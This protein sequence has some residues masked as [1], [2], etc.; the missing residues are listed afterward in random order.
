MLVWLYFHGKKLKLSVSDAKV[1]VGTLS[2][3]QVVPPVGTVFKVTSWTAAY[4]TQ[5]SSL[6]TGKQVSYTFTNGPPPDSLL[7]VVSNT[8][9]TTTFEV[10]PEGV[11]LSVKSRTASLL[12]LSDGS[13]WPSN[14][15]PVA[16]CY[17]VLNRSLRA[18]CTTTLTMVIHPNSKFLQLVF[19]MSAF[20]T[21]RGEYNSMPRRDLVVT[22]NRSYF[23][24]TEIYDYQYTRRNVVTF[25]PTNR[26]R[27]FQWLQNVVIV[28]TKNGTVLVASTD[29]T[30]KV[31][32]L[33]KCDTVTVTYPSDISLKY[34][35]DKFIP[36]PNNPYSYPDF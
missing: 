15:V 33:L 24:T 9:N 27:A 13:V 32:D 3:T 36:Q 22:P 12:T 20:M 2:A 31:A 1:F 19:D 18:S 14:L 29:T 28:G 10:V 11:N 17:Q 5:L 26:D 4:G 8:A 34:S 6:A 7:K 25:P 23:F 21:R 30:A 16:D 35:L